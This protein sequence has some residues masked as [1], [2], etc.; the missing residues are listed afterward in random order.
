MGWRPIVDQGAVNTYTNRNILFNLEFLIDPEV[1]S[2]FK[3]LVVIDDR[4]V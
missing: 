1:Q 2:C 3:V 4:C